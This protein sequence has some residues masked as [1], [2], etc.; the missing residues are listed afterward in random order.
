MKIICL[1]FIITFTANAADTIDLP[2]VNFDITTAKAL[3]KIEDTLL[4]PEKL[5]KRYQPGGAKIKDK[6]VE[7]GQFQFNATK[8][9]M[10][11]S[12]TV[13]VHSYFDVTSD[14]GCISK[15]EKGYLSK[16]DFAGSDDLITDNIDKYE[17]LICVQE[18][19][20]DS[21]KIKV[22]AKL[23]KGNSYSMILGPIVS[24]II[25]AQTGPLIDAISAEV[26]GRL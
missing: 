21:L 24:D 6:S 14:S 11:I 5:I 7:N 9:I 15:K 19:S 26:L 18:D 22:S 4:N 20:P 10:M 1:L 16:M 8:R 23:F 25:A 12:K 17:A 2:I 13:F 3:E